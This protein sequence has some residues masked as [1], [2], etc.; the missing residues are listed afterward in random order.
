MQYLLFCT[1][2]ELVLVGSF[3]ASLDPAILPQNYRVLVEFLEWKGLIDNNCI[4]LYSA[5]QSLCAS[6]LLLSLFL[7]LLL[8]LWLLSLPCQDLAL[9]C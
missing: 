7:L 2:N 5:L 8:L 6:L 9:V 1:I 3:E 4:Y